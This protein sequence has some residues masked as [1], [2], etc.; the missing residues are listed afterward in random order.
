MT[1]V[2]GSSP[3]PCLR[4]RLTR[5]AAV[6][7]VDGSESGADLSHVGHARNSGP[8]TLE[9]GS[10]GRVG[11]ALPDGFGPEEPFAGKV[12]SADAGEEAGCSKPARASTARDVIVR[13]IAMCASGDLPSS[14]AVGVG[15]SGNGSHV[16]RPP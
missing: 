15:S 2:V 16:M 12:E 7:Q 14:C 5:I 13:F 1:R 6:Q 4:E 11:F 3:L 10:T 9:D 8:V